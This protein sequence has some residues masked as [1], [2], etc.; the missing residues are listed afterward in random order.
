VH[1]AKNVETMIIAILFMALPQQSS[2]NYS[3]FLQYSGGMLGI[4]DDH[5]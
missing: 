1:P 3:Q 2:P 4:F 5:H